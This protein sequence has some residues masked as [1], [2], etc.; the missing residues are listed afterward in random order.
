MANSF[1]AV[2]LVKRYEGFQLG[3]ISLHLP[4]GCIMGLV[5]ENG[6]GKTT[7]IKLLTG[8]VKKDGGQVRLLGR[9]VEADAL[10]VRE[11][12]GVVFDE[13]SF[14]F[15]FRGRDV[16]TVLKRIY[17]Q[18]D[19]ALYRQ[20]LDRLQLPMDKPVKDFSRGMKMKL[21]IAAA[22]AHRPRLLLLDEPTGGL[23]PIVRDE[24]LDVFLDFIADEGHSILLSSHITAD[25]EKIADYIA[26]I[27]KGTLRLCEPKDELLEQFGVLKC[28]ASQFQQLDPS[29][30]YGVRKNQFGV[31]VLVRRDTAPRGAVVDPVRIDDMM[32]FLTKGAEQ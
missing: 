6:A 32:L 30:A 3:P 18:W 27:H 8:I 2:N 26:F 5:G 7:L 13:S 17:R 25:L 22:L 9:T 19:S 31:E 10:S 1:E 21:Q 11:D 29:L 14:P 20:Y 23:D 24:I 12:I 15:S 16:D 4:E 28:T